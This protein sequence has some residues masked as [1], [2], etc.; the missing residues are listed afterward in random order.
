M[1][2]RGD[3]EEAERRRQEL[4]DQR[5]SFEERVYG[6]DLTED[7]RRRARRLRVKEMPLR[8][9]LMVHA[10]M[11]AAMLQAGFNNLPEFFEHLLA[12]YLKQVPLD[13]RALKSIP[14]EE[15]LQERFLKKRAEKDGK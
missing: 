14:P 2:G 1:H 7:G 5:R 13:E 15:V 8:M 3:D 12:Q 10:A 11:E 4:E 9:T 6:K